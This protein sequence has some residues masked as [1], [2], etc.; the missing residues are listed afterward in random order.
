VICRGGLRHGLPRGAHAAKNQ[1]HAPHGKKPR[2]GKLPLHGFPA[3]KNKKRDGRRISRNGHTVCVKLTERPLS[4]FPSG[5]P[6]VTPWTKFPTLISPRAAVMD[7]CYF[8]NKEDHV[9]QAFQPDGAALSG[10][11]A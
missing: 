7:V 10:W 11:K 5:V 3:V 1:Q 4:L 2:N 8:G 9:G 6:G